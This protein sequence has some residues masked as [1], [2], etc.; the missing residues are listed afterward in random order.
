MFIRVRYINAKKTRRKSMESFSKFQ[1]HIGT[2]MSADCTHDYVCT[3]FFL[4]SNDLAQTLEIQDGKLHKETSARYALTEAL[5]QRAYCT[6]R[7]VRVGKEKP[8][9]KWKQ[10]TRHPGKP[11]RRYVYTHIRT[12]S[13]VCRKSYKSKKRTRRK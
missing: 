9:H 13:Y 6:A 7:R 2:T 12:R 3:H 11:Q 1:K 8:K 10:N 5:G 4:Y